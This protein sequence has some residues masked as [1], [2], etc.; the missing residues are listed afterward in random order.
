MGILNGGKDVFSG[1]LSPAMARANGRARRRL[2]NG[3]ISLK[4]SRERR[5]KVMR[6]AERNAAK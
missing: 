4:L 5:S 1:N 6:D 3:K 2:P